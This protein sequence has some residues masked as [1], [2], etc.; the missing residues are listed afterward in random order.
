MHIEGLKKGAELGMLRIESAVIKTLIYYDVFQYPLT[1]PEII[2]YLEIPVFRLEDV[3]EALDSLVSKLIVFEFGGYYSLRNDHLMVTRRK[4]GNRAAIEVGAKAKQM[5]KLISKFPFIESISI[6]GSLSKGYFDETTDIDYFI[7][8]KPG[9]LWLSRTLLALYKKIFLFNNRKYFCIN[10]F[11]A[12]N[13]LEIPDKNLF[14]ATEIVT[15]SN[16]TGYEYYQKFI[17]K[18]LWVKSYFPNAKINGNNIQEPSPNKFKSFAEG[19]LKGRLGD[20]LDRQC[21][22]L[23][24]TFWKKKFRH[25][26]SSDYEVNMRSRKDVSKHHPQGFQFKVLN[27]IEE[28]KAAL[29]SEHNIV[30]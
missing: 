9:R 2:Q 23:T 15:L 29:S 16:M 11:V 26:S 19:L 6:S 18:N 7:I 4:I 21:F 8:T 12:D 27:A 17:D 1:L 14:S 25:M 24:N 28:R 10:Y 13:E 5:S 3:K 20:F 30:L 22:K